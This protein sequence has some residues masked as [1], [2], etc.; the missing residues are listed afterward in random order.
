MRKKVLILGNGFDINIGWK[1]R[2]KDFVMS[3]FWPLREQVCDSQLSNFLYDKVDVEC[4]FDLELLLKKYA[5]DIYVENAFDQKDE[6]FFDSVKAALTLFIKHEASKTIDT[7]SLAIQVLRACIT[8]GY[9][10][11]IYS[12]NYTDLFSIAH[13]A[14]IH[15][16]FNYRS[17]HGSVAQDSIILGIDDL[18]NTRMGYSYLKKVRSPF[19]QSH[20]IRFDLQECD[21]VVFFGHSLGDIDYPYFSDFF[22]AQSNCKTR[23]DSKHIT[24]FTKDNASRLLILEQLHKMNGGQL[25]HLINDNDFK[26]VMTEY[27]D[28]DFLKQFFNRLEEGSLDNHLNTLYKINT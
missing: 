28:A 20:P 22:E 13:K 6:E 24:I 10:S 4:W 2:Y 15:N 17:V 18:T 23:K 5:T 19:Y 8:N 1:T 11:S 14:L 7:N 26:I 12:F 27:P 25:E 3:H 16:R 9:F 21:E